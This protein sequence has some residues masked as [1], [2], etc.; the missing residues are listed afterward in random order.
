MAIIKGL[1]INNL[2][3][4]V[5]VLSI[6]DIFL[7]TTRAFINKE[8]SSNINKTGITNHII[9]ILTIVVMYWVLNLLNYGEF[10]TGFILFYIGS[11]AISIVENLGRMG[12]RFPKKLE[13]IFIDLQKEDREEVKSDEN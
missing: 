6:F 7:G 11:Y 1:M 2:F 3:L 12:I 9:T 8:V 10:C 13:D 5:V 4:V